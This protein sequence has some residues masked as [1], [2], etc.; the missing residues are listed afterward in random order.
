MQK[1][2]SIVTENIVLQHNRKNHGMR[3]DPVSH[4]QKSAR[5]V[6]GSARM[7]TVFLTSSAVMASPIA[8]ITATKSRKCA[9]RSRAFQIVPQY[10]I[11]C[12]VPHLELHRKLLTPLFP[13]TSVE[14]NQTFIF[15]SDCGVQLNL[16]VY[17]HS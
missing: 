5:W 10:S 8:T 12:D 17:H 14:T 3:S 9:R 15:A 11:M 4:D 1:Y 7:V 2:L 16:S 6:T 13:G